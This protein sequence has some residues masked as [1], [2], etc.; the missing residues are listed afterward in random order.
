M[1]VVKDIRTFSAR[2]RRRAAP[3]NG[4]VTVRERNRERNWSQ[5][6]K[7]ERDSKLKSFIYSANLQN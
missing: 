1:L 6:S 7:L 4:L 5:A 2:E 3:L